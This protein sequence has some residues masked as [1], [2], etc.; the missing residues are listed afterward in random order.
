MSG[1]RSLRGAIDAMCR[2]CG[3]QDGGARFW[4]V[5]VSACPCTDCPLWRVR[6][7]ATNESP[8]AWLKSRDPAQLPADW[9]SLTHEKAMA[10]VRGGNGVILPVTEEMGGEKGAAS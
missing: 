2:E 1:R 9:R 3:G 4:R 8:P 7:I 5:H 10:M 6:P